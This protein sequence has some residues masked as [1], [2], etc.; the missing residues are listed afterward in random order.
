MVTGNKDVNV[1]I[2]KKLETDSDILNFSLI[3]KAAS[4]AC[5]SETF[6]R[7]KFLNLFPGYLQSTENATDKIKKYIRAENFTWKQK[8]LIYKHHIEYYLEFKILY[9]LARK[10]FW[11]LLFYLRDF[12][13]YPSKYEGNISHNWMMKGI[14]ENGNAEIFEEMND[15]TYCYILPECAN[16]A[17]RKGNIELMEYIVN[18]RNFHIS[19]KEVS[20]NCLYGA[21][22]ANNMDLVQK[23]IYKKG[24]FS[25]RGKIDFAH[26]LEGAAE[27]GHM[28]LI[29]YF[30]EIHSVKNMEL[31]L[32]GA[33]LGGHKKLVEFFISKGAKELG[34]ALVSSVKGGHLDLVNF[35]I[36]KDVRIKEDALRV[37]VMNGYIHIYEFLKANYKGIFLENTLDTSYSGN[38]YVVKY[39]DCENKYECY[40]HNDVLVFDIFGTRM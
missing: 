14:A 16:I 13:P 17:A 32:R 3:N 20:H 39:F 29:N 21:A 9:M 11:S 8:Y 2:L 24:P 33:S 10:G 18:F 26:G 12:S 28:K 35:F 4:N 40:I 5:K 31:G 15:P 30:M 25:Y 22:Y 19:S 27:G 34:K 37:A 36:Q 38:L 7:E 23:I 6:W 1:L